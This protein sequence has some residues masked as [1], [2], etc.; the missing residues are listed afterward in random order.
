MKRHRGLVTCEAGTRS[1]VFAED[2][3]DHIQVFVLLR[4]VVDSRFLHAGDII[5]F[6]LIDNPRKPGKFQGVNVCYV[7]HNVA[8]QTSASAEVQHE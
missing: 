1:F 4:D 8:R 2:L 7:A 5:E 6:D 3:A